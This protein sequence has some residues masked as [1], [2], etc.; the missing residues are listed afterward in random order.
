MTMTNDYQTC[1][2]C[3]TVHKGSNAQENA[4]RCCETGLDKFG[5]QPASELDDE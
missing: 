2:T 1:T 3:G 5:F 4:L